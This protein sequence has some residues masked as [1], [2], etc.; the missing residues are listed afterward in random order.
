MEPQN[1][2]RKAFDQGPDRETADDAIAAAMR[3]VNDQRSADAADE[4]DED[5][6]TEEDVHAAYAKTRR[7]LAAK[8]KE[9]GELR[10]RLDEMGEDTR[11]MMQSVEQQAFVRDMQEAF[12]KDPAGAIALMMD[13]VRLDALEETE[14]RLQELLAEQRGFTR[15]V[16]EF[17]NEP[18]NAHLKPH[19]QDLEFLV[20][21]KGIP[22]EDAVNLLQGIVKRR[23]HGATLRDA[24][25]KDV[26]KASAVE[27]VG[28]SADPVS[29]D[30]EL[31]KVLKKSKT[32]DEMFSG[33]SKLKL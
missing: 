17:L 19:E 8:E 15:F 14:R 12:A 28:Q 3:S 27:S 20:L 5:F 13:R 32:L 25:S 7:T 1:R 31:D 21:D 33:L 26:R 10:R 2:K 22:P 9:V 18:E 11:A 29:K 6:Q 4:L 24:L 23:E 16:R 30:R